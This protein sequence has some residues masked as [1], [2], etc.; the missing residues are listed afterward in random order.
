M[1]ALII[2]GGIGGLAAAV[3]LRR[4]GV[5]VR[6]F[7]QAPA[8]REA[9]A[10]LSLWSNATVHLHA[11]G[12][13]GPLRSIG[14]DIDRGEIRSSSGRLL[15]AFRFG[16]LAQEAGAPIVG[17]HR[18]DLLNVL[19][20]AVEPASIRLNSRLVDLEQDQRGVTATFADGYVERGD[21][22]IGADGIHSRAREILLGDP[23]RYAG[24]VGWRGAVPFSHPDLPPGVAKWSY[25]PGGQF[26]L[27]PIGGGRYFWFGT[28]SIVV[29]IFFSSLSNT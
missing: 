18:A 6:V 17:V 23:Q 21:L 26:G 13:A 28:A 24:Y 1:T 2:G 9:G 5:A 14:A 16:L 19:A 12:L 29:K 10:G 8:L 7:E 20:A 4:A 25:G 11:W 15:A 22:L 3:A 27:V